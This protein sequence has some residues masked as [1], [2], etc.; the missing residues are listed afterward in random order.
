MFLKVKK[1]DGS[2]LYGNLDKLVTV[3]K[4]Q[5]E[6]SHTYVF[7]ATPVYISINDELEVV[8]LESIIKDSSNG[9]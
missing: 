7:D 8:S 4:T 1:T 6:S 2:V 3:Q 5:G 9:K